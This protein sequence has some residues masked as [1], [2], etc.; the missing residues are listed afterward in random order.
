MR[1][2][3]ILTALALLIV[4]AALVAA[5]PSAQAFSWR[6]Y[7][8]KVLGTVV[9]TALVWAECPKA[10]WQEVTR[11]Q[12]RYVVGVPVTAALGCAASTGVRAVS[13]AGDWVT[14]VVPVT[15][16]HLAKPRTWE[17]MAPLVS[18]PK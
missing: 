18:I 7:G 15:D 14:N 8:E 6:A 11:W 5:P 17:K 16:K 3:P 2:Q 13:T 10:A 9:D 1:T 4:V 12:E